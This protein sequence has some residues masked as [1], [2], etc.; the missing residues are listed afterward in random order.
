MGP[1][2]EDDWKNAEVF[3]KFLE[4]F[5]EVT[6]KFSGSEYVTSNKYFTEIFEIQEELSTMINESDNNNTLLGV[7]ARNMKQKYDKYW[8]DLLTINGALLLAVVLD[9]RYKLGYLRHC[10]SVL[11][12]KETCDAKMCEIEAHL[13]ELFNEYNEL[14]FGVQ[15][16]NEAV[17]QP[18][19]LLFSRGK[20]GKTH[21]AYVQQ[22]I[23]QDSGISKNVVDRYLNETPEDINGDLDILAWW[24]VNSSKYKVLSLIARDIM[25]IPV[26]TV[27]SE[28]AFSTGGRI[29]DPFR[30][31]LS[32]KTVEALICLRNWLSD[33]HQPIIKMDDMDE[34]EVLK[35][36]K[37]LEIGN[38]TCFTYHH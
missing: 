29:L 20:K 10:Y 8:G 19:Q 13:R 32:Y 11:H 37:K 26:T 28:S 27:A 2:N 3:V 18:Q 34:A 9:P 38:F 30:S 5:Y 21:L 24:K 25:A 31:S 35:K 33:T 4:T 16:S 14:H 17:T 23:S 15:P 36:S 7:M 6:L 1:P 22:R 12:D